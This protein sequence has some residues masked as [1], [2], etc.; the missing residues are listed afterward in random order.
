MK[1]TARIERRTWFV[2][3]KYLGDKSPWIADNGETAKD[4][5]GDFY[6]EW[7]GTKHFDGES[8]LKSAMEREIE[9]R[10][11]YINRGICTVGDMYC[12]PCKL[13]DWGEYRIITTVIED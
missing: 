11:M 8:I 6:G 7:Q 13:Q 1:V 9:Y 2:N 3:G 4:L 10:K 12:H 5:T